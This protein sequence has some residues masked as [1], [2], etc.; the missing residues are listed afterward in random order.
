MG[1]CALRPLLLRSDEFVQSTSGRKNLVI[2]ATDVDIVSCHYQAHYIF[3]VFLVCVSPWECSGTDSTMVSQVL[4]VAIG[5]H[6]LEKLYL[7]LVMLTLP[8]K[9]SGNS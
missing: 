5:I 3:F 8:L 9:I 1:G 4:M 7:L 2:L 6:S